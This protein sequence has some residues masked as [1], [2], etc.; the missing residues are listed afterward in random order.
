M[1]KVQGY[2]PMGCG[3]TLFLGEGGFLT[4][5]YLP[6][7]RPDALAQIIGNKETEHVVDLGLSEFSIWHPLRERIEDETQNL[8]NCDLHRYLNSLDG[9]PRVPGKYRA[10]KRDGQWLFVASS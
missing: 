4:C 8:I 7:P 9:P 6:C 1:I 2:C 5:S 3:D 10:S